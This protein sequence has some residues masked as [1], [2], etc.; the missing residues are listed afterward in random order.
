MRSV[1]VAIAVTSL[2][3]PSMLA[4]QSSALRPLISRPCSALE[5]SHNGCGSDAFKPV[6]REIAT[7]GPYTVKIHMTSIRP[8]PGGASNAFV[9]V[10]IAPKG[11]EFRPSDIR[12]YA[13]DCRGGYEDLDHRAGGLIRVLP[14]T[15]MSDIQRISCP[16]AAA[17]W[18]EILRKRGNS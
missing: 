2:A 8:I 5:A 16:I 9:A 6:W 15:F 13:L 17:K 3:A 4:A 14:G 18:R 7:H 1:F 10:Y 12:E 11:A